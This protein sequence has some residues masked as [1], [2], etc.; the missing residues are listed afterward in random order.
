MSASA[1]KGVYE[2]RAEKAASTEPLVPILQIN[3]INRRAVAK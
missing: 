2:L 1:R 3:D